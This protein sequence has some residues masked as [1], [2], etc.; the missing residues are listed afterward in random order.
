MRDTVSFSQDSFHATIYLPRLLDLPVKNIRKI[1]ILML[2][3]VVS[4][5]LLSDELRNAQAVQDT[6][7]FLENIVPES[8]Q[9]WTAASVRYQQEWRLIEKRTTVRRTRKDIERDAAIR[10]H[11]DELTRAVK[12]AKSQYERWVKIQ[13]LWNDTKLK[14]KIM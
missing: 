5:I 14:M 2:S 8:K 9:A 12:K 1:F 13:A 7:L 11:N 10:A 6:E 3:D 4:S